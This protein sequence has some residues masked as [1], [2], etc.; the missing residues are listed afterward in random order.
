MGVWDWA[1]K[2]WLLSLAKL[3]EISLNRNALCRNAVDL[4]YFDSL[5]DFRNVLLP[6][7][8]TPEGVFNPKI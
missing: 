1:E 8:Q 5:E 7:I 6:S 3:L 4:L 2:S